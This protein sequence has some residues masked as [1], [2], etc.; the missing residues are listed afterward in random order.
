MVRAGLL[1]GFCPETATGHCGL[2]SPILHP[3]L[4]NV[5]C[6]QARTLEMFSRILTWFS[7]CS[8]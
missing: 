1:T 5:R 8:S 4:G 6:D 2:S 7:T 3:R